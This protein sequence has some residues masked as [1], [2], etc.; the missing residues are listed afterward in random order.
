MEF[1]TGIFALVRMAAA[2][3]ACSKACFQ[4]SWVEVQCTS[5]VGFLEAKGPGPSQ[6]PPVI[7]ALPLSLRPIYTI[8]GDI[9]P[10]VPGQSAGMR[11]QSG[12][13]E[14]PVCHSVVCW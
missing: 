8:P 4:R 12:L 6:V 2:A 13:S 11:G 3:M 1:S 14:T 10:S 7:R 9:I 5:R